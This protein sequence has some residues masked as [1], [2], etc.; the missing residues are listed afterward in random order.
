LKSRTTQ[1]QLKV[2][3]EDYLDG[4]SPNVQDI[5]VSFE[6]RNQVPRLSKADALGTLIEKFLSADINLGPKPVLHGNGSVKLAGLDNHTMG[7]IFEELVR[8]F[9]EEA[10]ERRSV[11]ERCKGWLKECRAVATRFRKLAVHYLVPVKM[12]KIQ[13][14]LRESTRDRSVGQS[15]G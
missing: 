6:F 12:A 9:N 3:F 1:Q 10:Y 2:D 4:F 13:R 5:L 7:T 15:P 11:V 8:R 14:C